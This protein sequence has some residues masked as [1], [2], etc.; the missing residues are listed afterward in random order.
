M[1]MNETTL[2]Y[3]LQDYPRTLFPL[4]TTHILIQ[5]HAEAILK[6]I[7]EKVLNKLEPEYSFL[8]QLHCY[9]S[10]TGFHLRRTVK[11]DP[12]SELFIYDLVYRNRKK[13]RS[14]FRENRKSFGY[15]FEGGQPIAQ[16][17]SYA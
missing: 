10:K 5:N 15:R 2:Q 9:A 7:Y 4:A 13:F 6:Y 8:P 14:D 17:H 1:I 16:T 12:V 3:F 11:L